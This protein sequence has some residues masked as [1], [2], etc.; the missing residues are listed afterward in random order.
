M[1]VW[2]EQIDSVKKGKVFVMMDYPLKLEDSPKM[3]SF[4][5]YS[6]I[7]SGDIPRSKI[8]QAVHRL[9]D[10]QAIY[11]KESDL[12]IPIWRLLVFIAH[13]L[14]I[15]QVYIDDDKLQLRQIPDRPILHRAVPLRL[16]DYEDNRKMYISG[17]ISNN[18]EYKSDF[19]FYERYLR[20][21]Y[22]WVEIVNPIKLTFREDLI[23]AD[24]ENSW[25]VYMWSCIHS[26]VDCRYFFSMPKFSSSL[27]M[28]VERVIADY[29]NLRRSETN[30]LEFYN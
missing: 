15:P 8:A 14:R 9:L 6:Q 5:D 7:I 16:S 19:N 1:L 17:P 28:Y 26:L 23:K 4:D 27:G 24:P 13:I 3:F 29:L 12:D 11:Y 22:N 21:Q 10:C 25:V 20:Y 30:F 2:V 18:P